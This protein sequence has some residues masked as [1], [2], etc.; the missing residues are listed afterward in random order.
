LSPLSTRLSR[1]LHLREERLLALL[2]L[3]GRE[4][5]HCGGGEGVRAISSTVTARSPT[6][7][8]DMGTR[9]IEAEL[10]DLEKRY[11]QAIK[12]KDKDVEA[13]MRLTAVRLFWKR[14]GPVS[15][16]AMT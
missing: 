12:D 14:S 3:L 13:E 2:D 16:A 7:E 5:R 10:L 4:I 6:A 1:P 9:T 15:H 8:D 11:W